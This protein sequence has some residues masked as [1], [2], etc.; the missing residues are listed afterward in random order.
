M[1]DAQVEG[2]GNTFKA[3]SDDNIDVALT[4]IRD[5]MPMSKLTYVVYDF[6]LYNCGIQHTSSFLS[7][8]FE[9][10]PNGLRA[11]FRKHDSGHEKELNAS[12]LQVLFFHRHFALAAERVVWVY[13][14]AIL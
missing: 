3:W 7:R 4:A 8:C 10:G 5:A 12:S 11:C 2:Y 9:Y 14:A 6:I 1:D 13:K